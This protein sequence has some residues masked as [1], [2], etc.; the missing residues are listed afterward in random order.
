[1]VTTLEPIDKI[2]EDCLQVG[3]VWRAS[4][5]KRMAQQEFNL[6]CDTNGEYRSPYPDINRIFEDYKALETPLN[7]PVYPLQKPEIVS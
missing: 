7:L 1:M 5:L 6:V 3:D 2:I 4:K